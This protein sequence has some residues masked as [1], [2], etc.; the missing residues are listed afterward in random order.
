MR[1]RTG[2]VHSILCSLSKA[3]FVYAPIANSMDA[4]SMAA[5]QVNGMAA[6]LDLAQRAATQP[7]TASV[8][9]AAAADPATL[10]ALLAQNQ[11]ALMARCV[12]TDHMMSHM[13]CNQASLALL[14]VPHLPG[15]VE[16][17]Q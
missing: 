16:S 3:P 17:Y 14:T 6:L 8:M 12:C 11:A 15:P 4:N 5:A 1:R 13:L 7:G 10:A 9:T 2:A